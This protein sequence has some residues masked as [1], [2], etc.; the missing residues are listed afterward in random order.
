MKGRFYIFPVLLMLATCALFQ[1]IPTPVHAQPASGSLSVSVV[2]PTLPADGGTYASLVVSLMDSAGHRTIALSPTTVYLTSSALGVAAPT[3]AAVLIPGGDSFVVANVTTTALPGSASILATSAGYTAGSASV[4]TVVPT[5]YPTQVAVVAVPNPAV[6]TIGGTGTLLVELLDSSGAPALATSPVAVSLSTSNPGVLNTTLTRVTIE[7]GSFLAETGFQSGYVPGAS[8]VSAQS[9]G[10]TGGS[11]A[12]SVQGPL[13]LG[14]QL[15]AQPSSI[16]QSCSPATS[17][18]SCQGRLVVMLVGPSG[19]PAPAQTNTVVQL[20]SSS[21]GNVSLPSTVTIL[22]GQIS[23]EVPFT[24]HQTSKASG[25]SVVTGSADGLSSA[26][27]TI[28]TY[29]PQGAPTGLA[30]YVGPNPILADDESYSSVV[31]S[32]VNA[33]GF[34]TV[35]STAVAVTISSSNVGVGNFSSLTFSIPAGAGYGWTTITSTYLAGPTMLTASAHNL[36]SAQQALTSAGA[37]ATKVVVQA[38]S[39]DVPANGGTYP[40]L[41][42]SLIDDLGEPAIAP[43]EVPVFLTSGSPEVAQVADIVIIPQGSTSAVVNVTTTQVPGSSNITA[44][45]SSL[46]SAYTPTWVELSTTQPSPAKLAAYLQSSSALLIGDNSPAIVVQLENAGGLPAR[47]S[48]P[49]TVGV[50]SSNSYVVNVSTS[51]T[52]PAGEDFVVVP[53]AVDSTGTATLSVTAEGLTSSS[54]T[55]TVTA[56]PLSVTATA[57]PSSIMVGGG[58]FLQVT[59]T[60]DGEGIAGASVLWTPA[61]GSLLAPGNSTDSSGQATATLLTSKVG[62][63]TEDVAVI[64]PAIGEFIASVTVTVT[65][66]PSTTS[67]HSGPTGAAADV[68]YVVVVLVVLGV[69]LLLVLVI[70]SRR[71]LERLDFEEPAETPERT[72]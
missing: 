70:R 45:S 72:T 44:Y 50:V 60:L 41:K 31:A 64:Q 37:V 28:N 42:V 49:V 2:P 54:A 65:P 68:P 1:A 14:L 40:A 66:P 16:A 56:V 36:L 11:V 12:V 7:P 9:E 32:L 15:F 18:P 22:A 57:T 46:G 48:T 30:L 33:T 24:A 51:V 13:P 10:L 6:A 38:I 67:T 43:S 61:G 27:A 53:L 23:A 62:S 8:T 25:S 63:W 55:L 21:Q 47:A 69:V 26:F 29:Q 39:Q 4:T 59:A 20:R 5:G 71:A 34:P 58:V 19:G 52:V 17:P 3:E 35:N